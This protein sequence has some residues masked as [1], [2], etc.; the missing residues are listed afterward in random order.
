MMEII[1]FPVDVAMSLNWEVMILNRDD[2]QGNFNERL[3]SGGSLS[4]SG[5]KAV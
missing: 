4:K 5:C 3:F 2:V 1:L